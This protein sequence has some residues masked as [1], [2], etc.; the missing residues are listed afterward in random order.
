MVRVGMIEP[1][2]VFLAPTGFALNVNEFF[3]IDVLTVL[4]RVG[5]RVARTRDGGNDTRSVIVH[6]AEQHAA[7][8]MGIRFFAVLAKSVVVGM[9]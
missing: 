2:N 7:A 8:F 5:T 6:A 3:G 1:N 9:A 4:R